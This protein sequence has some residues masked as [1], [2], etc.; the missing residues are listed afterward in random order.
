MSEDD[1]WACFFAVVFLGV[2]AIMAVV[3]SIGELLA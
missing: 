3:L 1:F 2:P